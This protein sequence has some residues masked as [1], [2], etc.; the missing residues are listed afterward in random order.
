MELDVFQAE[1]RSILSRASGYIAAFDFTLNA[2][3]G[4]QFGCQYCY[5]A[6]FARSRQ[7]ME[8]WG[9]WVVVKQNAAE[10]LSREARR[11]PGRS[12]YMSSVTDPYQPIERQLGLTRALLEIM[13]PHQPRLVVQTRSP[14][15]TRDLDLLRRFQN[16]RVN[17]TITTDD[18]EVRKAFEP[19]CPSNRRRLAA[20]EQVRAAGIRAGV[21][22]TPLLPVR[23]AHAFGARLRAVA[24]DVYVIQHFQP[25]AGRFAASTRPGAAAIAARHDWTRADYEMTRRVLSEYVPHL[26]EGRAGFMPE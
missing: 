16:V 9:R 13:L 15:V 1:A 22:L 25:A 23:D 7:R 19:L 8:E 10:L 17:M 5:A 24:A 2:Y 14:L 12:V 3:S 6:A 21:C 11:L 20:V 18:D 4:C 26:Y